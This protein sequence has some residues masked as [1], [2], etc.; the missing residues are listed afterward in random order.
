MNNENHY[1][2]QDH[3][4]DSLKESIK[5]IHDTLKQLTNLLIA[6]AET[7]T[8]LSCAISMIDDHEDRLR[9]Q[10]EKSSASQW[11]ER[12]VWAITVGAV[13]TYFNLYKS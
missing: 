5:D 10:E 6:K 8:K 4:F 3:R 1:C 9:S 2:T 7:D 12:L 13:L 11:V